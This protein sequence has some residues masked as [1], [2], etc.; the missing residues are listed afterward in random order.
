MPSRAPIPPRV[1]VALV[2]VLPEFVLAPLGAWRRALVFRRAM[3]QFSRAPE[4]LADSGHPLLRQLVYGWGNESFSAHEEFLAGCLREAFATRGPILE[5]GAG[6][7]TLLVGVVCARR[8][9][10]CWSYE[11][12]AGWAQRVS[13][14]LARHRIRSVTICCAPLRS[15][16]DFSWYGPTAQELPSRFEL[17][18]CDGPPASTPGGRYGLVPILRAHLGA[19]SVILL[20]DVA[21]ASERRVVERWTA[22]L[23]ATATVH[24]ERWP[25]ARVQMA[26]LAL[27]TPG[28]GLGP[29]LGA[30]AATELGTPP[31]S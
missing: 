25:Y 19:G 5:C 2:R 23:P 7:S 8:G 11:H 13:R 27:S 1:L 17:V 22:E 30:K 29:E 20:D 21:R 9:L 31:L 4:A 3:R 10:R 18:L 15:Y 6:L 12:H 16:G 28:V 14:A 26:A 24:G